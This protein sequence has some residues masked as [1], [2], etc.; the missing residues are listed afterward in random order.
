MPYHRCEMEV[1]Y[2]AGKD[3]R[4][5][6]YEFIINTNKSVKSLK[7]E[8]N[9]VGKKTWILLTLTVRFF[10]WRRWRH[11]KGNL[12]GRSDLLRNSDDIQFW[13]SKTKNSGEKEKS[14]R[15]KTHIVQFNLEEERFDC[16]IKLNHLGWKSLVR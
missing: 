11:F 12:I 13:D 16:V 9:Y 5:K 15:H 2:E 14:S 3:K 10:F 7:Q 1:N 4:V 8:Y 6:I